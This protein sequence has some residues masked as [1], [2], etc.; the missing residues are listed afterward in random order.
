MNTPFGLRKIDHLV[1]HFK[2]SSDHYFTTCHHSDHTCCSAVLLWKFNVN[3]LSMCTYGSQ[4]IECNLLQAIATTALLLPQNGLRRNLISEHFRGEHPLDSP[5]VFHAHACTH[6]H[7]TL[8]S[9]NP[10][11]WPDRNV[12]FSVSK[13][14]Y[15]THNSNKIETSILCYVMFLF[16]AK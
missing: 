15:L 16:R 10:S 3:W 14:L 7:Q 1:I 4:K 9:D 5:I 8:H 13:H 11:Y 12:H 6:A 2:C